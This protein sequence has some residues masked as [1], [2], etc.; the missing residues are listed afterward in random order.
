MG[1]RNPHGSLSFEAEEHHTSLVRR[2]KLSSVESKASKTFRLFSN[3]GAGPVPGRT[4]EARVHGIE[5]I[6]PKHHSIQILTA[7]QMGRKMLKTTRKFQK[8]V[9][10]AAFWVCYTC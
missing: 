9:V 6:A 5:R 10:S 4:A 3:P 2:N 8:P 1:S 7:T